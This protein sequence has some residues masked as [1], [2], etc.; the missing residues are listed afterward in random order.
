MPGVQWTTT[1]A[2]TELVRAARESRE[3]SVAKKI[4]A[5]LSELGGEFKL[6]TSKQAREVLSRL[7]GQREAA[8]RAAVAD[9]E[10]R[11]TDEGDPE[12]IRKIERLDAE[13]ER[14][15]DRC[16]AH[17]VVRR[18]LC[19]PWTVDVSGS[20]QSAKMPSDPARRCASWSEAPRR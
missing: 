5:S 2:S 18:H 6:T 19:G 7:A 3:L 13:I 15:L 9:I 16:A 4:T 11:R 17:P 10:V 8:R 1:R 20:E 12:L 14:Y